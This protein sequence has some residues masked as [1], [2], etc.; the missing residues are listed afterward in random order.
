MAHQPSMLLL[1]GVLA[2]AGLPGA[3]TVDV[4]SYRS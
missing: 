1:D 3:G 2:P 4:R